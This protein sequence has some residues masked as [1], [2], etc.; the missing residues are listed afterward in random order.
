MHRN[1][2]RLVSRAVQGVVG[3]VLRHP[4]TTV[5]MELLFTVILAVFVVPRLG[6]DMDH[7]NMLDPNLPFQRAWKRFAN[8]FPTLDD[9]LLVVVDGETPELA[10]RAADSLAERLRDKPGVVRDVYLPGGGRFFLTHGLL[11]RTPDELDDFVDHLARLQPIIAEL[12]A[13]PSIAR[14]AKLI[15]LGLDRDRIGEGTGDQWP[16]VLDRIG[17]ATVRVFDEYPVSVSWERLILTGSALE[18]D[19]RQ[20][21]IVHPRL[22]FSRMLVAETAIAT[23]R[24]TVRELHLTPERGVR[25]RITGNPALNYEEMRQL[26]WD[27]GWS[28]LLSL[29]FVI[30]ILF[31]AFGSLRLVVAAAVTLVVGLIWTAAFAAAAVG[32][33]NVVSITFG[34]LFVGLG[35]DFAIHLGMQYLAVRA[36]RAPGASAMAEAAQR[37]GSSLVL[38]AV[39]TIIGFC[40]F[41]PTPYRGV[42][43]LGLVSAGGMVVILTLTL[44]LFPALI[45]L[46]V[47]KRKLRAAPRAE[48][49]RRGAVSFAARHPKAVVVTAALAFAVSLL[50][51]PQARFEFDVI[52][53]RDPR[54]ESVQ[55]FADLLSDARRSPWS[56][57][58]MTPS[59]AAAEQLA[60]RLR[61]LD[62]VET[63]LT[64]RDYVPDEQAEK[65]EILRDASLLLDVPASDG[66][67]VET[68]PVD[69]Q[70]AAL[71]A[72]HR[73]LVALRVD[74]H[75]SP[76]AGAVVR[77]RDH[78]GGFLTRLE[79][80]G[81]PTRRLA[82]LEHVLL[83]GFPGQ[84]RRLRRALRVPPVT[85][86]DLPRDLK[87]RMLAADGQARVQVFP[88]ENLAEDG[89]LVRFVDAVEREAPGATGVAVHLVEFG[90][91]TVASMRRALATALAAIALTVLLLFGRLRDT[92]LVLAP[93]V[94]ATTLT[95]AGM[96]L[97]SMP[98]NFADVVVLPLLL[99]VGVDSGI[100]LVHRWRSSED[101]P[102][103]P[104]TARAVFYSALT[105]MASFA[106]LALSGHG[107]VRSLGELLV[108][109]MTVM[110]AC[111]LVFL[112]ALLAL[113]ARRRPPAP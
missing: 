56:V 24:K 31:L 76:L 59:L 26:A 81:D 52:K 78:L 85:L 77:L 5:A 71:R 94:L 33:L 60:G 110:L 62:G 10:R 72:L 8:Y 73:E 46:L 100:H 1:L 51:V 44:T 54:T 104:T 45:Q 105:T 86:A 14:L 106:S 80:D 13:D 25:V 69:E 63:A 96:T 2:D 66:H 89:A 103:D 99:G 109:G 107:G 64:L 11:Y 12:A 53:M 74:D 93:V 83:A 90:R 58:V 40:A 42:A 92:A 21:L 70:V 68:L 67:A 50:L 41:V 3:S 108:L 4:A 19:A 111:N 91:A 28:S 102:L 18:Q 20:V 22:D 37:T 101:A 6:I 65:I 15:R 16:A 75:R 34:V 39:T 97:L 88:R 38:C 32:R 9:A 7:K 98:F 27:I 84:L 23:I 36:N 113:G 112:P 48:G 57:D 61:R 95:V 29:A 43:Q 55:A 82:D 87:R 79:Q 35:I 17:E 49:G 47:G 30:V